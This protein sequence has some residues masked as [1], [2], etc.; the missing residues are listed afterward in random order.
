LT[1]L[2]RRSALTATIVAG[3]AGAFP[4]TPMAAG[5]RVKA[6]RSGQYAGLTAEKHPL[7]L[8]VSGKTID[9]AAFE[10]DCKT[11]V[12]KGSLDDLRLTKTKRGYRFAIRAY[13]SLSFADEGD[14]ENALVHLSGR[15]SRDARAVRGVLT[16]KSPRCGNTGSIKWTAHR[17]A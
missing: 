13:G 1:S 2:M 15:F 16:V 17:P 9:L 14:D 6:P 4:P 8:Y 7:K 10:F 5:T 12:G 3:L 11:T